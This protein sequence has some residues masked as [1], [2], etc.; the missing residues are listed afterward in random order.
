MV[1]T[2]SEI[3]GQRGRRQQR[4]GIRACVDLIEDFL[5]EKLAW[6]EKWSWDGRSSDA[7]S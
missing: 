1:R 4:P 2:P 6:A 5:A 7:G 3:G